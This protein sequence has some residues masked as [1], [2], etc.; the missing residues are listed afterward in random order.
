MLSVASTEED[1]N[2][3]PTF[4]DEGSSFFMVEVLGEK[5][6]ERLSTMKKVKSFRGV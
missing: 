3:R 1:K 5:K 2:Y 6:K 4:M